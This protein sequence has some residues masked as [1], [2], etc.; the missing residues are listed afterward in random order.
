MAT[1]D[2]FKQRAPHKIVLG[3]TK[4]QEYLIPMEL[5]VEETERLLECQTTVDE[6]AKKETTEK[7]KEADLQEFFEAIL[8]QLV[9]L[10]QRYQPDTTAD[11]LKEIMTREDAIKIWHFF[12]KEKSGIKTKKTAKKKVH[13]KN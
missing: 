6:L 10:F 8:V 11:T 12:I 4:P 9:V 13:Q 7:T 3:V 5:T 1:L 2:L